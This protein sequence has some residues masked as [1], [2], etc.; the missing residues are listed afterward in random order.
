MLEMFKGVVNSPETTITNDISN[1]DTLIYVLDGTRV[2]ANLPNIMTLDTGTNAETIKVLS[3]TSNAITVERGFQGIAKAW[4]AGTVISRNFTE[5]DYNAL[6]ENIGE[7]NS[8]LNERVKTDVPIGAK[9]TDTVYDDSE[10][11]FSEL[12]STATNADDEG[13]YVNCIWRRKD[14]TIYAKSNLLGTSPFYNQIEVNYYNNFGNSIIKTITWNVEYDINDF[15][16][17]KEVSI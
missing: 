13:I 8:S 15:P 12:S 1:T 10:L 2:P 9:F 7:V 16:Y 5:Y 17:K 4:T 11:R 14:N 6:I 3:I